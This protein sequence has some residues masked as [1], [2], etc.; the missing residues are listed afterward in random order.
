MR[1]IVIVFVLLNTLNF[2][3]TQPDTKEYIEFENVGPDTKI[4]PPI[5]ISKKKITLKLQEPNLSLYKIWKKDLPNVNEEEFIRLNFRLFVTND[6]TYANLISFISTHEEF[7]SHYPYNRYPEGNLNIV[8]NGKR[9]NLCW[10]T[11]KEFFKELAE[12]L[13][14]NDCDKEIINLL[15]DIH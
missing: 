1:N 15:G 9:Y 2:K 12:Y 3:T 5:F 13:K 8:G 4:L 7:Y 14:V 6:N 10:K 11:E